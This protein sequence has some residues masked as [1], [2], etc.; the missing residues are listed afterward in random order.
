LKSLLFL[1]ILAGVPGIARPAA[2]ANVAVI[3]SS[4]VEDYKE[5]LRGFRETA[6]QRIVAEYDMDEDLDK[7]RRILTEIERKVKPDL[8]LAVGFW[9]LQAIAGQTD[10][11]VV[12]AM[13]PQ[14]A[15]HRG[16]WRQEQRRIYERVGD[17]GWRRDDW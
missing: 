6:G 4:Q 13:V 5:A 2:A 15:Q 7:G 1:L 10:I 17:R 11:P 9:A 12:Y 8:I 3:M 16:R 14:P